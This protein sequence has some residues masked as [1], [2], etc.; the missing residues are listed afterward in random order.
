MPDDG[1]SSRIRQIA[2]EHGLGEAPVLGTPVDFALALPYVRALERKDGLTAAHTWRVTLYARL[3]S[4]EFGLTH[5]QVNRIGVA[6]SL[7]DIGKLDIPDAVLM[8][9]GK[10]TDEEFAIIKTHPVKGH[11]RLLALGV[12]DQIALNLVRWHHERIDGKGYPDGVA[13]DKIPIGARF[14]SVIDTFDALTSIRPYRADVGAGAGERA[15][16]ELH[17][18]VGTRYA[19][20]AVEAFCRLFRRGDLKWIMDYFN[21]GGDAPG[22]EALSSAHQ[23]RP[24]SVISPGAPR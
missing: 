9:P 12:D 14:F 16:E 3:L 2:R 21:D 7:H 23:V 5:E 17:K 8:K 1:T 18:G 24:A 4:E 10:L 11:E 22:F 13:G 6:A 20:E 15:L 19:P